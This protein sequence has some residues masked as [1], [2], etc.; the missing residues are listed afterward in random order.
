MYLRGMPQ[1]ESLEQNT[2]LESPLGHGLP[3]KAPFSFLILGLHPDVAAGSSSVSRAS[4]DEML[5]V[6]PDGSKP[7]LRVPRPCPRDVAVRGGSS[8]YHT[9][10]DKML[11]IDPGSDR[12]Y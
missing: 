7:S 2:S 1:Q 11:A 5:A 12:P 6:H 3:A 4:G 9:V 8:V 10:N